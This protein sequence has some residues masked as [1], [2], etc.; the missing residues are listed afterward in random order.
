ML[1]DFLHLIFPNNCVLCGNH[2]MKQ[3]STL[4]I[5]CEVDLPFTRFENLKNNQVHKLFWGRCP[6]EDAYSLLYFTKGGKTQRL[7]HEFKYNKKTDIGLK[8]GQL[9][10][11]ELQKLG[12]HTDVV[13]PVPLHPKKQKWRGYNQAE[14]IAR[15]IS[16]T[17]SSCFLN[18]KSFIRQHHNESQTTMDRFSRFKNTEDIFTCKTE[19]V[20]NDQHVLI[21]DDVITT[22]S[23]IEACANTI[24][25]QNKNTKVSVCCIGV[26]V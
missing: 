20:F 25:Q 22:G 5:S 15:G 24:L 18:T 9:I 13:V 4:C 16:Q 2:L 7:M 1:T 3:E 19:G 17:L 21:A 26:A 6:I 12:T 10:G 14:F 8:M 23:T 11:N